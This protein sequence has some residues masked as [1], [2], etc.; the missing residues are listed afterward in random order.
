[1][2]RRYRIT[3]QNMQMNLSLFMFLM[4]SIIYSNVQA[5]T[6]GFEDGT[7]LG[8]TSQKAQV[9]GT[10]ETAI[11]GLGS[12]GP[13]ITQISG[14]GNDPFLA[15][16]GVNFPKVSPNGGNFSLKLED[17]APGANA[18]QVSKS[19]TVTAQSALYV[20]QYAVILEDPG[21]SGRPFF[22]AQVFDANN[23]LV[24]CG[25]YVVLADNPS[26]DGFVPVQGNSTT[27]ISTFWYKTWTSVAVNLSNLIG[28]Q[29]TVKFTVG[30]CSAGEHMAFAYIDE[31]AGPL[32]ADF[33]Q[34]CPG[35]PTLTLTA[36]D[37][38][39]SYLWWIPYPDFNQTTTIPN[40]ENL[41]SVMCEMESELGNCPVTMWVN[42]NTFGHIFPVIDYDTVC[43]GNQVQF[44]GS[45]TN[46]TDNIVQYEWSF[47]DNPIVGV[48]QNVGH[49]FV[50]PNM[51]QVT[52]T[53]TSDMGC[54]A[55]TTIQVLSDCCLSPSHIV[56]HVDPCSGAVVFYTP[57]S[58]LSAQLQPL[59]HMTGQDSIR[60]QSP[61]KGLIWYPDTGTYYI[62]LSV[63]GMVNSVG[64]N[65][66][67][68]TAWF[69]IP[70]TNRLTLIPHHVNCP[71]DQTGSIET[72]LSI[73]QTS[74][75]YHWNDFQHQTTAFATQLGI[76]RYTVS[77][78][79]DNGCLLID[80][81]DVL[82]T[83][84][85]FVPN[86]AIAD[87][88]CFGD[89]QGSIALSPSG[90]TAPFYMQWSNGLQTD[91]IH[92]LANGIYVLTLTDAANCS[93]I[94][95]F[96][97]DSP[98]PIASDMPDTLHVCKNAATQLDAS[99]TG[100]TAPY[101]Y[102]WN[103][104]QSDE[105]IWANVDTVTAF[106]VAVTDSL[107]C[108]D[109]IFTTLFP[110][111]DLEFFAFAQADTV[112]IGDSIAL[113]IHEFVGKP[114]FSCYLDGQLISHSHFYLKPNQ[115]QTYFIEVVDGCGFK[116]DTSITLSSIELPIPNVVCDQRQG[117]TPLQVKLETT[118]G[119]GFQ[120]VWYFGNAQVPNLEF[121]HAIE[122]SFDTEGLHDLHLVYTHPMGCKSELNI[123]NY[124]NAYPVPE[125]LFEVD[126]A[127]QSLL[128]ARF[129]FYNYSQ[130]AET[131][132]WDFADG[133]RSDEEQPWHE[134]Q[135]EGVY[136]VM[137]TA[138]NEF[139]CTDTISQRV[140]VDGVFVVWFPTIFTP[141][142]DGSND[143]MEIKNTGMRPENY[144]FT[145]Y[146]RW[147]EPIWST[148]SMY[149]FWDGTFQGHLVVENGSYSWLLN[150]TD[151][152]G[153]QR[154]FTGQIL[155][156]R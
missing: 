40:P 32:Q 102:L 7:M 151:N 42:L 138:Q 46:S 114:A 62:M 131:F 133:Q 72:Q 48:G 136:N 123:H 66:V 119:T 124:F 73:S 55:D 8:W 130:G 47:S 143:Y 29:I 23:H 99:V 49:T 78:I 34:Y 41:D 137:L 116:K 113:S 36:P 38:F 96:E 84:P 93:A 80:S 67:T 74:V 33:A 88:R 120:A 56:T 91:E 141:D 139:L 79:D 148:Q 39:L 1:M 155:V 98:D 154:T 95:Q 61:Y 82:S 140:Y 89:V 57:D 22:K 20:Y 118:N 58:L 126:S 3:K 71:T 12:M 26:A 69:Y 132:L 77:V 127:H 117:C 142:S 112:C 19:F 51:Y 105:A 50:A 108:I 15:T 109:Q 60:W 17:Y 128:N 156:V 16:M 18:T 134:Y 144:Q 4:A 43:S 135:N 152:L 121:G 81:V 145:V 83:D 75:S 30:D 11:T 64:C 9:I 97:I 94:Y 31:S 45:T 24:P 53:V 103:T 59:W 125:A 85:P 37:G 14:T 25:E 5:Q 70:E 150:C 35:D 63:A 146:D 27:G 76:G 90:G 106:S 149:E 107:N 115:T 10:P 87:N 6:F 86:A 111:P 54:T 28:Q 101:Q 122:H 110:A 13:G 92:Q 65:E 2:K 52:L 153:K 129:Y 21:H 147:G 100:G 44:A 68:D 104:G